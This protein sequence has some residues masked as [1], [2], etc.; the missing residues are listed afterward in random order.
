M[1]KIILGIVCF[2]VIALATVAIYVW[3]S[4]QP[5]KV[6]ESQAFINGQVLTMD[7]DGTIASAVLLKGDRIIQVGS[8]EDILE[9]TNND[10]IVHDLAGRTLIPGFIDAHGHFPG[11]GA[12]A[13]SADLNAP[14]IGN[15]TTIAELQGSLSAMLKTKDKNEWLFGMGYDDTLIAEGR[16]PTREDLD[17]VS[18]DNPIYAM[19]VSGHMGVANSVALARMGIDNNTESPEGG[20]IV[21]DSSGNLTGLLKETATMDIMAAATNFSLQ[22]TWQIMRAASSEYASQGVTTVQNGAADKRMVVGLQTASRYN[23]L[24]QRAEI[25]PLH[26]VLSDEELSNKRVENNDRARLGAIKIVADGSIQGYTGYLSQPYHVVPHNESADFKGHTNQSVESL[27]KWVMDFHKRGLQLAIHGNGD[28]S[29]EEILNAVEAAQQAYPREDPRHILIH[30]QMARQDQLERMKQLGITPSFFSAHTYYWGDRHRD[31]FMGAER[32]AFMSPAK[33]SED[34]GLRYTIHLDSPVVPM[35]PL[36]LVWSAV[37]RISSGGNVIGP[38]QRISPM[39]AL[40]A[41]TIDAAWQTFKEDQIGSIESGKL[42]DLVIL[43]GDPLTNPTKIADIRVDATFVG[44]HAI[45][46]RN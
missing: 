8:T 2:I 31:I 46:Q 23:L 4:I 24:P 18:T 38:E 45:Y 33:A 3:S 27:N 10:T 5:A 17:A 34:L 37:N 19:H 21:K 42:A 40:R 36:R 13:V 30:A 41:T 20:V 12:F 32:A 14:P 9:Q 6:A 26:T 22:E 11:S 1:K 29:I 15:V 44:G 28:Q 35:Q 25:W 43:N 7:A 39:A 16:H